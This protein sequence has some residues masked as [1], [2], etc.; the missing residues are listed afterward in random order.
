MELTGHPT[1]F[2]GG[3]ALNYPLVADPGTEWHY[4]PGIDWLGRVVEEADGRPIDRFCR[5]RF[6]AARHG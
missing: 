5:A 4:G 3:W 2:S 6:F 1:M